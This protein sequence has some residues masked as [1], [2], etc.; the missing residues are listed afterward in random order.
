MLPQ[1]IICMKWGTR[2]G[3]EYVNRLFSMVKRH[4]RRPIRL[5]CFTDDA[6]GITAG[7][8]TAPLPPI[9]LPEEVFVRGKWVHVRNLGWRKIA[10][11]QKDVGGLAGEVLFLDLDLVI[12]GPLDDFFDYEPGRFCVIRNWTQPNARIGNTS[13]YRFV[14]GAHTHLY[15]R[16]MSDGAGVIAI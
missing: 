15:E 3:P 16:I 14:V 11:W 9:D 7:V 2:Y 4:S 5:I 10:L 12:T 1:T 6:S 8:E 13:V